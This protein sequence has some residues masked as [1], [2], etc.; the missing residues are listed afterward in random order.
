[1]DEIRKQVCSRCVER[2]PDGPPCAPLGKICGVEFHL[3][4]YLDAIHRA[5]SPLIEPY[6]DGI[7]EDVCE[8]CAQHDHYDACPCP[9]DYLLGLIVP[10]VEAVDQ[11]HQR[12]PT[13]KEPISAGESAV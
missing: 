3:P 7:H 12:K 13:T 8:H 6:L 4:E 10:I 9:L 5:D 2:P 11:R 1:M